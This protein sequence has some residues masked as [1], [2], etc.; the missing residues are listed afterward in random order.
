MHFI[1]SLVNADRAQADNLG[2]RASD[3][4]ILKEKGFMIPL[5]FIV[6]NDAFEEFMGENGLKEKVKLILQDKAPAEAFPIIIALFQ[7]AKMPKEVADEIVESY[8]SLAVESGSSAS[9]IV[10]AYEPSPVI[11]IRS[12]NYLLPTEDNEGVLQNIKGRMLAVEAIKLVWATAYSPMSIAFRKKQGITEFKMG[13]IIQKMRK[14]THSAEAYSRDEFDDKS[15]LVKSYAGLVDFDDELMGKDK[16]LIHANSLSITKADINCQEYRIERDFESEDLIK[17][18][19]LENSGKQN[20]ND[21]LV[22]EIARLTK[23]AKS[24]IGHDIKVLYTIHDDYISMLYANRFLFQQKARTRESD[25]LNITIDDSGRGKI[26][27]SHEFSAEKLEPKDELKL[28]EI[29][30]SDKAK[31]ELLKTAPHKM[32][33]LEGFEPEKEKPAAVPEKISIDEPIPK[34]IV[35]EATE[36]AKSAIDEE[37]C[38][39][40][41]LLEQVLKIKDIIERME[42]H[43]LNNNKESYTREAKLL[44]EM[45]FKAR[46]Q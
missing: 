32:F 45:L 16:H 31:D 21:K 12:P 27:H 29:M 6:N 7:Q 43:A 13:V 22:S 17:R 35:V 24:F 1:V 30:S 40:E 9:N 3:L 34:T 41:N 11:L 42:E 14:T 5:S 8:D 37:I 39:G 2:C 15:I 44:K 19:L 10:S 36:E 28:P 25:E 38:I 23:R 46:K 18:P 26:E 33:T 4:G 20:I